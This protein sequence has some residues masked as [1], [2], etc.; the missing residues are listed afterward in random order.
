MHCAKVCGY[1]KANQFCSPGQSISLRH[2]VLAPLP[3][4]DTAEMRDGGTTSAL[5]CTLL[6][7]EKRPIQGTCCGTKNYTNTSQSLYLLTLI[8]MALTLIPRKSIY[9]MHLLQFK[10]CKFISGCIQI[11]YIIKPPVLGTAYSEILCTWD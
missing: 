11:I 2:W 8:V 9:K 7:A 5:R 3:N 4:L 10:R 1:K 6:W